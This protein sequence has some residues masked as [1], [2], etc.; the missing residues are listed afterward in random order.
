MSKVDL[1]GQSIRTAADGLTKID[2]V[3]AFKR[4][5]RDGIIFL[6]FRD[7]DRM[8]SSC[9]GTIY[10][11]VPLTVLCEVLSMGTDW[12]AEQIDQ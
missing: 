1:T 4:I 8:R 9:R 5:V 7:N 11:E 3:P 6:Q 12:Q 2:G 10:I